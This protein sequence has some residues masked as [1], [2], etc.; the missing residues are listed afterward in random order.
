MKIKDPAGLDVDIVYFLR[1]KSLLAYCERVLAKG[2]VLKDKFARVCGLHSARE[3]GI[4]AE[5]F[6]V[7]AGNGRA[8]LINN[9]A[10]DTATEGLGLRKS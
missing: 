6:D 8:A 7:R 10:G 3:S 1:L 9:A 4:S 2:Q 5:K